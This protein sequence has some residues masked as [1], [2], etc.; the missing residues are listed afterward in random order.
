MDILVLGGTAWLGREVATTLLASGHEV[1]CVA[2]SSNVPDGARLVN[3]DRDLHDAL[4]PLTGQRWDAVVD[5]AR[6]PGHVRRAA[7]D[8]AGVADRY[9]LVS[10]GNV[11]ASQEQVGA[12]ETAPLHEPLP[13]DS[14]TDPDDYGPA[15]VACENAVLDAFDT[16]RS[17]IARAG[18]IG[19]P[20]DHTQRTTYWPWRFANPATHDAVL[21]PD[22]PDLP[23][24]VIDVRDLA[25]WLVRCL[26]QGVVGV[27]NAM[28]S[29]V[30]FPDHLAAAR[31]AA[32][33]LADPVLAPEQWLRDQDVA[34]WGGPHSM[35]LWLV[36]PS[37]YGFNG[38]SNAQAVAAGLSLRPLEDTLRDGLDWRASEPIEENKAG[39]TDA[40][41]ESLL[42][43][44][45]QR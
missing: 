5:V 22:A 3:A 37:W 44:S 20:G 26:E 33:S 24:A 19:G 23:V 13:A 1:T 38:R 21:V 42:N 34:E 7:R 31:R 2:R 4:L 10:T 17:L 39:L 27:Y 35:P 11:Y 15:K 41:E 9:V 32:G 43:T 6:Q 16:D 29:P 40:D 36:D 12:D 14:F 45:S 28:G 8:L 18:L 30:T 25:Q